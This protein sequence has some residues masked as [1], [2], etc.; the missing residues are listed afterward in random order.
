MLNENFLIELFALALKRREVLDIC[1]KH[2][3][4]HFIPIESYKTLWKTIKEQYTLNE[5]VPTVGQLSQI[6]N[7]SKEK[8]KNVLSLLYKIKDVSNLDREVIIKQFEDFIKDSISLSFYDKF[9]D[10]YNKGEKEEAR[11]LLIETSSQVNS[12][13]LR[14]NI[15]FYPKI[16][17]DF[18]KRHESRKL[19]NSI[20]LTNL[21]VP[22]SIDPLDEMT[23]GGVDE[24]DTVLFCGVSGVGKTKLLKH[25]GVGAARRGFQVLHVQGEGSEEECLDLYDATWSGQ[26][27]RNIEFADFSDSLYEELIKIA[28]QLI[29]ERGE[30]HV[31]SI[32][33]LGAQNYISEVKD[34]FLDIEK[35]YG[36]ID[37]V[38]LDYF[39]LFNP[40]DGKYYRAGE[41]R[42]RREA[43]SID[44]KNFAMELRTRVITG[45]QASSIS[46]KDLDNPKFVLTRYNIS[47]FKNVIKPFSYF[48]TLNQTSDEY[49]SQ[50]MRIYV[51]KVRKYKGRRLFTIAQDY[52][53]ERFY[54]RAKTLSLLKSE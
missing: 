21:K 34:V 38:L 27:L 31:Y 1:V 19:K 44:I 30:I 12:F 14:N 5:E 10:L 26:I 40:S 50:M 37:L 7:T 36:H 32:E 54:D 13:S 18:T 41:E 39:E 28:N 46:P 2:L 11:K 23:F 51:D 22:F 9:A 49:E 35:L 17:R 6:F 8:D 3:Q 53:H 16:F 24:K 4:F 47:E 25:I 43:L 15:S 29:V 45:T 20:S 33:K 42:Q 48:F 52:K